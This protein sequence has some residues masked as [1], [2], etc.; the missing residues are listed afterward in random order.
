MV[1]RFAA[2]E[3]AVNRSVSTH[4]A[5]AEMVFITGSVA[6]DFA[7]AEPPSAMP[8]ALG[9]QR[10]LREWI[11]AAPAAD[12]AP[13]AP[14]RGMGVTVGGADYSITDTDTDVSGWQTLTVRKA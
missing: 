10:I 4:L 3:T 9:A 12:F 2:L 14:V 11:A 1:A 7:L 5:N 13:H 8:E 6:V